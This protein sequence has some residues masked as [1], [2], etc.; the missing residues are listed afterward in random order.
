MKNSSEIVPSLNPIGAFKDK[1]KLMISNLSSGK[2]L[3][4]DTSTKSI[5]SIDSFSMGNILSSKRCPKEKSIMN[6]LD[7]EHV[8]QIPIKEVLEV[9]SKKYIKPL[10][11]TKKPAVADSSLLAR[12]M[13]VDYT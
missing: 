11:P 13:T 4:I 3:T 7:K 9:T 12:R 10:S 1:R 8:Y 6:F 2:K 5:C